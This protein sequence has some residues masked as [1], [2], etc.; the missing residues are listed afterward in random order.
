MSPWLGGSGTV[1]F[2]L[3]TS[4][5][6]NDNVLAAPGI[7]G[8]D[9]TGSAN[10]I[11]WGWLDA[12]GHIGVQAG[13]TAG[14]ESSIAVNDGHWHHIALSRNAAT[15]AVQVFVDGFLNGSAISDG[16]AKTSPFQNIGQIDDSGGAPE[17]F[18]GTLDDLMLFNRVLTS[19]E[20]RSLM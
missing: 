9:A 8:V 2:W 18:D 16:G 20:I 3:N 10:D 19:A 17:H 4:Q 15:G 7:L 5:A 11:F 6:G 12:T 14:A 1:A 13:A